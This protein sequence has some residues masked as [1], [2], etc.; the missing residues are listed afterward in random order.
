[1]VFVAAMFMSIMD[2]TIVNVALPTIGRT[3]GSARPR[4]DTISIAYLVSLAVFIPASGW[5]GDRFGGKT[6][7]VDRHRGIHRGIGPVRR[8][9][10]PL[11]A[12]AF[13]I[14][15]GVGGGMLAPVGMAMLFRAFPP[16]ER[17]RAVSILTVPTALAPALGP[18]LGGLLVTDLS[19]RWVFYVNVPIGVA[20]FVFGLLFLQT[21]RRKPT[22]SASTWPASSWPGWSGVAHVRRLRGTRSRVGIDRSG[23]HHC[24]R[25]W[26]CWCHGLRGAAH[27]PPIFALRLLGNR[28]F[29]SAN[30]VLVMAASPFSAP[31]SPS[32]CTFRTGGGSARLPPG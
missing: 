31:S 2:I 4:S 29:R 1:M 28:L 8:G 19:W 12:G 5:L 6:G 30:G 16:E 18:V 25:G 14:L 27:R 3:S 21:Q 10:E 13:R 20:A 23:D 11:R 32:S 24:R 26:S 9:L 22:G 7:P 15:Q 17:V